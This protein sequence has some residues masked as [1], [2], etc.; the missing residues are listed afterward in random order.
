MSQV[1]L[2]KKFTANTQYLKHLREWVRQA[3][4][5]GGLSADRTEKVV[6]G[7]NEACMNIIEHA[8]NKKPGDVIFEVSQEPGQL[9]FQLTDFADTIDCETI[10]SR[11]LDDIRPGGLGVHF[12]NQVMDNVEYLPG[13]DGAGNIIKM[14]IKIA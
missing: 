7:V 5:L 3:A 10:K 1:L 14:K 12:I 8:Y 6:I 4:Q 11:E 2:S 13:K 9:V